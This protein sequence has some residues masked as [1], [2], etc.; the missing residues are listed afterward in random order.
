MIVRLGWTLALVV[1]ASTAWSAEMIRVGAWNIETL[2]TPASRDYKRKRPDHGFG[3]ARDPEGLAAQIRALDLD[4]LALAEI[5]D[6]TPYDSK[7]DSA[8]LNDTFTLLNASGKHDWTYR[9]FAK[10]SR[11]SY[12]HHTGLAWDRKRVQS[13]RRFLRIKLGTPASSYAEWDR[14][15]YAM[16]FTRGEGRTDFVVIPI[17]M[18]AGRNKKAIEQREFEAKALVSKLPTIAEHFQDQDITLIGDFNMHRANEPA[19]D[20]YRKTGK[21]FDLNYDD[22]RT[23][24]AN[25]PLDRCYIPRSQRSRE[26]AGVKTLQI[27]APSWWNKVDFRRDFSDHWPIVVEFAEQSDDD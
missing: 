12:T 13:V 26:F 5:N 20:V 14:H 3:V 15:P 6:T 25:L 19:G 21:L 11:R 22:Q 17:P 10:R 9:L 7:R 23:H 24:I 4:V 1:V 2:G 8:L 27:A 18:K 16:K